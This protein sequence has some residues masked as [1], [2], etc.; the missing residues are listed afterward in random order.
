LAA[1]TGLTIVKQFT[2]RGVND[3]EWSNTYHFNGPPPATSA[4]W[5][6]L[7]DQLIAME[8]ICF[9]P[10]SKTVRAYGY[11]TDDPKPVSVWSYDYGLAGEFTDGSLVIA[12]HQMAGDQAGMIGWKLDKK[13]SRG[14]WIWLR[15][16]MHDAGVDGTIK[17]NIDAPTQANYGQF[18]NEV[19]VFHGGLRARAY[20]V[21][22]QGQAP[23]LYVTTRTLKRRG[24]RPL[25]HS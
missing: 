16:F 17:D 13:N 11:D 12:G 18:A 22:I 23:S 7:A 14:K 25:A 5:K 3:E 20:D 6:T 2:Y 21:A 9:R 24:K 1:I 15:K 4:A 10:S 19:A 8:S